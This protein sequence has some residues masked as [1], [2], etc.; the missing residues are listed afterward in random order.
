MGAPELSW[1]K[2]KIFPRPGRELRGAPVRRPTHADT[3]LPKK[4]PTFP[5]FRHLYPCAR[6]FEPVHRDFPVPRGVWRPRC[7]C[8]NGTAVARRLVTWRPVAD[9]ASHA[10][11]IN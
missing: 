10:G 1:S 5:N 8:T 9:G 2:K 11:E 6:R 4:V 3:G 7:A